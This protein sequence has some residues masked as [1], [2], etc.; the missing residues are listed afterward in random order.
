MGQGALGPQ[1]PDGRT[2]HREGPEALG[3]RAR[4]QKL[5]ALTYPACGALRS[6]FGPCGRLCPRCGEL[7]FSLAN[8]S[9]RARGRRQETLRHG[10]TPAAG[11][12]GPR[13]Q[14]EALLGPAVSSSRSDPGRRR[15]LLYWTPALGGGPC[16]VGKAGTPSWPSGRRGCGSRRPPGT[17]RPRKHT[18]LGSRPGGVS[19]VA[20]ATRHTQQATL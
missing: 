5:P 11:D 18:R 1:G 2:G 3:R 16:S 4:R 6:D 12:P 7:G 14:T 8:E 15:H 9:Q 20:L 10:E 19:R 17:G 13:P